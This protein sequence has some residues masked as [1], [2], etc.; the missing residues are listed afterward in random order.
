MVI[1]DIDGTVADSS[2]RDHL[3]FKTKPPD[4]EAF[5]RPELVLKDKL[6]PRAKFCLRRF[7][8]E[9]HT[10]AFLTSRSESLRD[11][12]CDWL[13]EHL[14][15]DSP[16]HLHMRPKDNLQ[17]NSVYKLAK[18]HQILYQQLPGRTNFLIDDDPHVWSA[19]QRLIIVLQAP[20]CWNTL[21]PEHP[22]LPP[23]ELWALPYK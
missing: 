3:V 9:G 23:E 4:W 5:L 1:C 17:L 19:C 10:I 21:W 20:H 15:W 8:E 16:Y 2:H 6:V 14:N 11:A 12:T 13:W 22:N 7:E 18:I